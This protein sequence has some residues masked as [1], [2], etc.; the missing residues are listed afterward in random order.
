MGGG[1]LNA[2]TRDRPGLEASWRDWLAT[3]LTPA[4]RSG[5]E[6]SAGCADVREALLRPFDQSGH[7]RPFEGDR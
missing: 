2:G 1:T 3:D 7:L 4:V 5:S 6:A